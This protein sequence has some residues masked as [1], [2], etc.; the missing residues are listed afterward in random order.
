MSLVLSDTAG[1][2]AADTAGD[3]LTNHVL[4]TFTSNASITSGAAGANGW[5]TGGVVAYGIHIA[6][7]A[8]GISGDN[9]IISGVWDTAAV[10]N[11]G[12]T[13]QIAAGDLVITCG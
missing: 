7:N 3:T 1:G 8:S 6:V 2:T 11:A 9:M 4:I 5:T 10:V 13:V 12:D